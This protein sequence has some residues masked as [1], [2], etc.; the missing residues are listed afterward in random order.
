[1]GLLLDEVLEAPGRAV[2][3][4]GYTAT[5]ASA[6]ARQK[7]DP[8]EYEWMQRLP[9]CRAPRTFICSG[10]LASSSQPPEGTTSFALSRTSIGS[11]Q[12]AEGSETPGNSCHCETEWALAEGPLVQPATGLEDGQRDPG[13]DRLLCKERACGHGASWNGKSSGDQPRRP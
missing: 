12:T 11:L 13:A 7:T 2:R 4:A 9:G 10:S 3:L 5:G 1:M 8:T 6:E